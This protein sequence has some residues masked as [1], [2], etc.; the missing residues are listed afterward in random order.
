MNRL[1]SASL[2]IVGAAA[3]AGCAT[4]QPQQAPSPL[5]RLTAALSGAAEVPGAGDPDGSGIAVVT[6][7]PARSRLCYT[8][9]VADIAPATAA[10]IHVGVAGQSGD[11]LVPLTAPTNGS[12]SGCASV[13]P[14]LIRAIIA[15][16]AAYYVNVHNA[17]FPGGA[18]RGQLGR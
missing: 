17:E 4:M 1:D 16:P 5:L 11:H 6:L 2:A 14:N 13:D 3:L 8:V 15:N 10:H 7:D 18:I 12:S 9:K